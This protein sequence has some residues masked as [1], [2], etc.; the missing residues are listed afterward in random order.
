MRK[1][2]G[3]SGTP[4]YCVWKT[5]RGRCSRPTHNRYKSYGGRG[6]SVCDRWNSFEL[7]YEDMGIGY[8]SGLTIDRI[9]KDGDYCP[10][11][12]RWTTQKEQQRNRRNNALVNSP[13]GMITISE[14]SERSGLN[15]QTLESRHWR[16][17]ADEDLLKSLSFSAKHFPELEDGSGRSET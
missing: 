12:C 17:W 9:D 13:W 5:M 14:L 2:H 1:T 11:N 6:I 7:F 8:A 15:R 10:E 4:L 16:G 3:M